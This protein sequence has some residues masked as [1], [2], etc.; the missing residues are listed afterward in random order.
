MVA[1]LVTPSRYGWAV[2]FAE[3]IGEAIAQAIAMIY[4]ASLLQETSGRAGPV[5]DAVSRFG[6][7]Q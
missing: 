6:I 3:A 4:N 1:A 7:S 2:R 5:E